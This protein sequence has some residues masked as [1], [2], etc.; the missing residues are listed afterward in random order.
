MQAVLGSHRP[1]VRF[2]LYEAL[3]ISEDDDA[4]FETIRQMIQDS[5][6]LPYFGDE[7]IFD[8]WD[9]FGDSAMDAYDAVVT[10]IAQADRNS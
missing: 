4:P 10:A 6:P 3:G 8:F 5:D 1:E 9:A 7:A 2:R